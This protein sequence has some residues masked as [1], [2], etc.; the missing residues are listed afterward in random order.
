MRRRRSR[1]RA[2]PNLAG[3]LTG[4][5]ILLA[6][7]LWPGYHLIRFVSEPA[8]ATWFTQPGRVEQITGKVF[9]V[10][11]AGRRPPFCAVVVYEY[12]PPGNMGYIN[13]AVTAH[14]RCVGQLPGGKTIE[15]FLA[16]NPHYRP[17]EPITVHFSR[18]YPSISMLAASEVG[19]WYFWAFGAVTVALVVAVLMGLM[20]AGAIVAY[21]A[22]EF[23]KDLRARE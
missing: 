23:R 18:E 5:A 20:F 16:E 19:A 17:G 22:S 2:W 8:I 10:Q 11:S 6:I 14:N 7:V 3:G 4:V 1:S 13:S 9:E 21:V 15:Q 12:R